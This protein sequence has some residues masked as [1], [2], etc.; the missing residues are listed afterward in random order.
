MEEGCRYFHPVWMVGHHRLLSR[1]TMCS[2]LCSTEVG[3]M[4][5]I[6]PGTFWEIDKKSFSN[7]TT[8]ANLPKT[9]NISSFPEISKANL[10]QMAM[11]TQSLSSL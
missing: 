3:I 7:S 2:Y 4:S 6:L 11:E 1:Y 5:P 9:G 8:K 10:F